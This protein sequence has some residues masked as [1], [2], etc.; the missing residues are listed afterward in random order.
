VFQNFTTDAFAAML[1]EAR[2]YRLCLTLSHQYIDQLPLPIRQA[3]FGNVGTLISFRVGHNDAEVLENEFGK[4]FPAREFV[5]LDRY[6]VMVKLLAHGTHGEPFRGVTIPPLGNLRGRP[7]KLIQRSREKYALSRARV[8][9]K[10]NRWARGD[11]RQKS[12][13]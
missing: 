11:V 4:S 10:L 1:A 6:Q 5:D 8:E 7:D 3:V 13:F 2:K 12:P 9:D